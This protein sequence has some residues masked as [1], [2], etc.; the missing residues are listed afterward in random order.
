MLHRY[1]KTGFVSPSE[2]PGKPWI[3][4]LV[5]KS[6]RKFYKFVPENTWKTEEMSN[7]KRKI[8]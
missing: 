1:V 8:K 6:P 3:F 2:N 4:I 7:A 5:L